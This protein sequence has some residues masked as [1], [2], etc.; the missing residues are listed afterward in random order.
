MGRSKNDTSKRRQKLVS[1]VDLR[2]AK[3]NVPVSRETQDRMVQE[4]VRPD[5]TDFKDLVENNG[6]ICFNSDTFADV[7][8]IGPPYS[9]DCFVD[10][11]CP[12]QSKEASKYFTFEKPIFIDNASNDIYN[13]VLSPQKE[14]LKLQ[15][16]LIKQ[17]SKEKVLKEKKSKNASSA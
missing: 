1:F 3:L 6:L 16:E 9:R 10:V 13:V 12:S 4:A 5:I 14:S 8:R 17:E 7:F 15:E 11:W 2:D